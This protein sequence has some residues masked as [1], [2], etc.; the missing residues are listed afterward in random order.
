M[1][2]VFALMPVY[3]DVPQVE[4]IYLVFTLM[5]VTLM[6]VYEDVPLVELCPLYLHSSQVRVTVGDSGLCCCLCVTYFER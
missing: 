6:P 4:F 5:P 2:L 3:K 1:N